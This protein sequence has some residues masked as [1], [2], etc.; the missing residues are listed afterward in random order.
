[1]AS[2]AENPYIFSAAA[3][4]LTMVPSSVLPIIASSEYFTIE[5]KK[6]GSIGSISCGEIA[7]CSCPS[8]IIH[9]PC[10]QRAP[11]ELCGCPANSGGFH[12]VTGAGWFLRHRKAPYL[13]PEDSTQTKP[14]SC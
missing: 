2:L 9:A 4:Q 1:M 11:L 6:A 12:P 14:S 10:T 7:S 13:L 3:F 5:A 8:L